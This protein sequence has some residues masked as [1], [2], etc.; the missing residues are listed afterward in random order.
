M[1]VEEYNGAE[2]VSDV[3]SEVGSRKEDAGRLINVPGPK[4]GYHG[5]STR[6]APGLSL[7]LFPST[8]NNIPFSKKERMERREEREFHSPG[9][10][11]SSSILLLLVIML[12]K[13]QRGCHCH[14]CWGNFS[15][16]LDSE[17]PNLVLILND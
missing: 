17:G 3:S 6:T 7:S 11:T 8:F 15:L 2:H 5:N 1:E 10:E 16:H 9:C 4:I 12:L 14:C 13:H